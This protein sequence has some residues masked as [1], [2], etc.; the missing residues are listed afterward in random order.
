MQSQKS[1][2]TSYIQ[3][4]NEIQKTNLKFEVPTTDFA[5]F[6]K[7][8]HDTCLLIMSRNSH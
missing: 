4:V 8:R 2:N 1:A 3:K 6:D 7:V 5:R